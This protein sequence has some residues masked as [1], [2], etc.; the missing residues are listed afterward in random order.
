MEPM[1]A[2]Q[3][4]TGMAQMGPVGQTSTASLS[5]G[6][7]TVPE[8][9][10]ACQA[11]HTH[12]CI[13]PRQGL[14]SPPAVQSSLS[15]PAVQ[16][17]LEQ[18]NATLQR[19]SAEELEKLQELVAKD[20]TGDWETKAELLGTGRTANSVAKRCLRMLEA[21]E[22][23]AAGAPSTETQAAMVPASGASRYT[24]VSWLAQS[25]MLQRVRSTRRRGGCAAA[26]LTAGT[27]VGG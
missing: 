9:C 21:T 18:A 25:R 13:C 2:A 26:W 7:A 14:Q 8:L 15:P 6:E 20:G 4:L 27:T 1:E 24:G 16:S 11:G 22:A 10:Y 12:L 23:A 17:S 5:S 19:W 3:S